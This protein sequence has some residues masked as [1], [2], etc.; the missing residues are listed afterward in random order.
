MNTEPGSTDFLP[1]FLKEI[2]RRKGKPLTLSDETK[3]AMAFPS[4]GEILK[5][6]GPLNELEMTLLCWTMEKIEEGTKK[7]L[8]ACENCSEPN[9]KE[10]Q[11]CKDFKKGLSMDNH[12]IETTKNMVWYSFHQRSNDVGINGGN[13]LQIAVN[14]EGI[15]HVLELKKN[16]MPRGI[17][18]IIRL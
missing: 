1:D 16:L 3:Q 14:A 4:E 10:E 15:P 7:K 9:Y 17:I 11:K 6:H 13:S 5:N 18:E 2:E 8:E 12:A